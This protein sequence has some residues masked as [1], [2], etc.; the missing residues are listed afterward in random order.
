[1]AGI[2][3][4]G[5]GGST[6][7]AARTAG[8]TTAGVT[9]AAGHTA[10]G[11]GA[12]DGTGPILA[13]VTPA[14]GAVSG[15]AAAGTAVVGTTVAGTTTSATGAAS[16]AA[17]GTAT[18][19]ATMS[20]LIA[21]GATGNAILGFAL[22]VA[23]TACAGYFGFKLLAKAF[24]NDEGKKQTTSENEPESKTKDATSKEEKSR[25]QKVQVE[26]PAK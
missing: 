8:A 16:G 7:T 18:K 24:G 22:I 19:T 14:G 9:T 25:S 26:S 3:P 10:A 2:I 13:H 17:L 12:A 6:T 15:T 23:A 5:A 1:M 11:L 4:T 21:L 20:K